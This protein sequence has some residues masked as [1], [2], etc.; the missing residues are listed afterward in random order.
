MLP[1]NDFFSSVPESVYSVAIDTL[2]FRITASEEMA[3]RQPVVAAV[4]A[5]AAEGIGKTILKNAMFPSKRSSD[6]SDAEQRFAAFVL[7][8]LAGAGV[9]LPENTDA[10]VRSIRHQLFVSKQWQL[11]YKEGRTPIERFNPQPGD[12]V[13]WDKSIKSHN[14]GSGGDIVMNLGACGILDG[15]GKVFHPDSHARFSGSSSKFTAICQMP[16]YGSPTAI[17]RRI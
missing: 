8:V 4:P 17:Y 14:V 16:S 7:Q 11:V 10:N 3:A 12:L 2:S 5:R 6:A 9:P 1:D 13:L 15:K